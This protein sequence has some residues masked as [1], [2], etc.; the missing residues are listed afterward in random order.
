MCEHS[1][2]KKWRRFQSNRG[3]QGGRRWSQI[4]EPSLGGKAGHSMARAQAT[5]AACPEHRLKG[6]LGQVRGGEWLVTCE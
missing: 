2:V 5:W 4:N 3:M 6:E 1:W